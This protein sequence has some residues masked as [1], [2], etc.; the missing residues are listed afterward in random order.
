MNAAAQNF[1][2]REIEAK[3][4]RSWEESRIFDA[5]IAGTKKFFLTVP[6]PYTSGPLHIG[7]GRTYT[8]GD[9]IARFKRLKG[10]NLLFP[11]AFHVTGTP[12]LAIADSIAKGDE[13]VIE[14]YRD[15]VSIYEDAARIDAVI[16]TFDKP[17]HVADF[18]A[19][20]I[21]EDF[22]RMGYSIDWRRKFNTTEPMYNRF[23]EWQFKKLYDKGV[24]K[25]GRYPITYSIEEGCA[26]GEDDIEEGDINKVS[27]IEHTTIKFKSGDTYLIAATLRPETIFGIT[28]LWINPA[29]TYV[30]VKVGN[31]LWIVS[32]E[33]AEKLGY[34]R[35]GIQVLE[36]IG[37]QE[38][39][40]TEAR[41][42]IE[43]RAIPIFPA[44]FVDGDVG[45]GVVYSVP[46]TWNAMGKGLEDLRRKEGIEVAPIKIIEIEGYD[47]PAKEICERMGIASQEDT[48][49]EEATQIIY[50]D[51]FYRGVMNEKCGQFAG[52]KIAAIKDE[53][54]VWLKGRN[55]ADVFYETSRKAVTRSGGKVI[56]AILQDQWFIDYTPQWWKELGHK[57]VDQ[58]SFYPEKYKAYMHDIIDWLA[59]RPCA[60]KRGLGTQFPFEKEWIIESL[61]DSTIY[62]AMY[63]I[64]HLVRQ[65]PVDALDERFFDYVF[66]GIGDPGNLAR[67]LQIDSDL[68]IRIKQEFDYWYPNDLR[69]T[70]PPHLSNHLVFFLMHHAAI[71]PEDKWPRAITL[72]ELMIR[73]GR[74]MSKSKGNV[75]PL[76]HVSELYG[77]DL[78]RLYCAINADFATVVNWRE[79]DTDALRK[80]FNALTTVFEESTGAEALPEEEF[81][82][83]DRWLLSTFYRRLRDSIGW[84][85]GFRI[86]EA[87]I[88][89]VFNLMNDIRYYEKRASAERR[90]RIVRNILEDWLIMLSPI[91]PH[92]CEE[93]WHTSHDTFI[94]LQTLPAVKDSY[95]DEQ[96]EREEDYLISLVRDIHEILN[97]ARLTPTTIYLYTAEL[98]TEHWKWDIFKALKDVPEKDRIKE[99]L[100]LRRDKSTVEFVQQLQKNNLEY[101]ALNERA[102]L[103]RERAYLTKEF[104]CALRINEEY[105]PKGKK[106]FALP[107]KPAIYV[108]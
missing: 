6:Y 69:H 48:R 54:K 15:Y 49:L 44:S 66:L 22:K 26:V 37:V 74:K 40:G 20:R 72:N 4:Q 63:T 76:A 99:A 31:E 96:V 38:L 36:E 80:R 35:E 79:Q 71:F 78:Y 14:R 23:I 70:A 18:F 1:N 93:L 7:H 28:N 101:F 9:I 106:R 89:M 57:L 21:S 43:G 65:V 19:A 61:S 56:V 104:G 25:K 64:A 81:S 29:A 10:Y 82:H 11:M 102:V 53:V 100:K 86:R 91:V 47:L 83:T 52:I 51:E 58:M 77:V 98:E 90:K 33:A 88:N 73:E 84:F 12:I 97:V 75:I 32:R 17:E 30:K 67:K 87:G 59:L 8:L 108:E 50:K 60:R 92:I 107:L 42:P 16:K 27:I 45:T 85:E 41:E 34:Q 2:Y 39:L 13:G 94:T 55:A 3:W 105:D 5:E 62:M 46:A 24:I 103:D 68:L 95:I